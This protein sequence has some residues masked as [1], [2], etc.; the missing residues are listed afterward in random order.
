MYVC[1]IVYYVLGILVTSRSCL[2]RFAT[3][4]NLSDLKREKNKNEKPIQKTYCDIKII[5][6]GFG[7]ITILLKFKIECKTQLKKFTKPEVSEDSRSFRRMAK[8]VTYKNGVVLEGRRRMSKSINKSHPPC[9]L[10]F[11]P[12]F[13]M[14]EPNQTEVSL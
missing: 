7:D 10:S 6:F 14:V 8:C 3:S 11:L 2:Y 5:Q 12:R 9:Y 1:A 4:L 13:H